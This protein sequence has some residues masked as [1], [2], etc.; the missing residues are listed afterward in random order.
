MQRVSLEIY[1]TAPEAVNIITDVVD[2]KVELSIP[3]GSVLLDNIL[4]LKIILEQAKKV[5]KEV[6]F[7]T[8]DGLGKNLL[9][10]LRGERDEAVVGEP[11]LESK[12]GRLPLAVKLPSLKLPI[13]HFP[14]IAF[15]VRK[16]GLVIPIVVILMAI[17]AYLFL[18]RQHRAAV[19]LYFSPQILTKSVGVKVGDGLKTDLDK[20]V[21]AGLKLSGT[22]TQSLTAGSTGVELEGEKAKG[23]VTLYNSVLEEVT[24]KK[25]TQLTYK[26]KDSSYVFTTQAAVT[27]PA[28]VDTLTIVTKGTAE[29]SVMAEAIGSAYNIKKDKALSVKGYKSSELTASS[30]EDFKGG[31]SKEV[32]IVTQADLT[33]LEQ[34]LIAY[35]SKSPADTLKTRVPAG[36]SLIDKS[37]KIS[38]KTVVQNN[39][40]GDRKDELSGSINAQVDGLAYSRSELAD[41]M[42]KISQSVVPQGFEFYS[43]NKELQVDVLGATEK[44]VLSPTEADLQ[45]TFKFNIAPKIDKEKVFEKIAGMNITDAVSELDKI[46]D[47]TRSELKLKPNL[48][49]FNKVPTKANAVDIQ[50]KIEE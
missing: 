49:L 36:Y 1:T 13:P 50:V 38:S 30:A 31:S 10:I 42:G 11:I 47:I 44:T 46:S 25:G 18:S 6:D 48:P 41:F 7:V 17:T 39:K 21:L 8:E 20:K 19:T 2:H 12:P 15:N 5:G 3:V 37:E 40:V 22:I 23:K 32:K 16:F 33:K 35:V 45:V 26:S 4:N 9:D 43:Y 29:V 27:I 24:L 34:D 14:A 28:G